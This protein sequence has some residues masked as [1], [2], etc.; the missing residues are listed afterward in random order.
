MKRR[1]RYR[2]YAHSLYGYITETQ[3]DTQIGL[4]S[5]NNRTDC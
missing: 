2:R 5:L 1:L 3:I 4:V